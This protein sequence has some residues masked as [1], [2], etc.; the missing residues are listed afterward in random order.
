MVTANNLVQNLDKMN[1]MKFITKNSWCFTLHIGYEDK[2][3]GE[4]VLQID[5]NE[6]WKNHIEEN[7]KW[8]MLCH[9]ADGLF[10]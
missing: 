9:Y 2:C 3:I 8:I 6:N 4:T 10:Q 5:N 7:S 1:E